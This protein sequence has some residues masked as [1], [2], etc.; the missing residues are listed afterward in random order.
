[1]AVC[2]FFVG[3]VGREQVDASMPAGKSHAKIEQRL[4]LQMMS[5]IG[6]VLDGLMKLLERRT[7]SL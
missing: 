4:G 6:R 1:M 2:V 7:D 5:H 3:Q